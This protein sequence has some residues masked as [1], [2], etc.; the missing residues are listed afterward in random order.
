MKKKK[1]T[2]QQQHYVYD[3]NDNCWFYFT[4]EVSATAYEHTN[5]LLQLQHACWQNNKH[6]LN[7]FNN[8]FLLQIIKFFFLALFLKH[9]FY[10][11]FEA[12]ALILTLTRIKIKTLV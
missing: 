6:V 8:F 12:S 10:E 2:Q 9:D 7:A 5:Q 1:K 3:F 4:L 11:R